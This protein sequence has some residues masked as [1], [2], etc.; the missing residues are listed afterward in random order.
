MQDDN[1]KQQQ[2]KMS[3]ELEQHRFQTVI[4]E[5]DAA[6]FEWDLKNNQFYCSEAYQRYAFSRISNEDILKNQGPLDTV[7]PDDVTALQS[8]FA[9]TQAGQDRVEVVLRLKLLDGN[10][11]WCRMIGFYYKDIEGNPSRTVGVIIDINDEHEHQVQL[12]KLINEVPTG[13]GVYDIHDGQIELTYLNDAYYA[14]LGT[15][16][17]ERRHYITMV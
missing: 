4:N 7:H 5:L 17:E 8:F 16:R 10:Y 9:D 14:M 1:G 3:A 6:L 13:I 2:E 12:Q 15:T 11:R